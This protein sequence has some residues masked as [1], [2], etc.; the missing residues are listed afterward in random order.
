MKHSII[1]VDL[2][3][4]VIQICEVRGGKVIS[5][6][7]IPARGFASWLATSR[8]AIIVFESCVTSNY[9]KQEAIKYGHDGRIISARLVARIRQNQKT[10]KNDALAVVQ[11]SQLVDI[12][13]VQGKTFAQQELQSLMRMRELTVQHCTA[14]RNQIKSLLLEFNIKTGPKHGGLQSIVGSVL[15]DAEN[16]FSDSFREGLHLAWKNYEALTTRLEHYE[17]LLAKTLKSHPECSKLMALEGVSTINAIN[18]YISLGTDEMGTFNSGRD[19]AACIGLTPIQHSSGGKTQLG[20]IGKHVKNARV[21]S[22]LISGAMSV[23]KQVARRL[24]RTAKEQWLKQLIERRGNK[25]AAVALANK[26]VRTA[27]AM[28]TQ[29]TTYKAQPLTS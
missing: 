11:A 29:G 2:A 22:Q 16:G 25:C 28:L 10:D 12:Q 3:K 23:V 26:T 19:A 15:E 4:E 8:K 20:T 21:R 27:F 5:N 1:G 24:P 14:S 13:F 9:W 18:L 7:E 17:E 6:K